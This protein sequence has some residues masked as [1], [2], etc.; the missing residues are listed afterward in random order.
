MKYLKLSFTSLLFILISLQ[1]FAQKINYVKNYYPYTHKA[2]LA[3]IDSNY[4]ESLQ[5]YQKAFHNV[6]GGFAK[7][8]YN[9]TVLAFLLKKEDIAF[10]YCDTLLAK[11]MGQ[12]SIDGILRNVTDWDDWEKW[13]GKLKARKKVKVKKFNLV[14]RKELEEIFKLDQDVRKKGGIE[15]Y[16]TDVKN[17]QRIKALI[18]QYGF[19]SEEVIGFEKVSDFFVPQYPYRIVLLHY[20]RLCKDDK[21]LYSFVKMLKKAIK[22]GELH[23]H[24]GSSLL[25]KELGE[26]HYFNLILFNI[27]NKDWYVPDFSEKDKK[28]LNKRRAK[29]GLESIEAYQKKAIFRNSK[30]RFFDFSSLRDNVTLPKSMTSQYYPKFKKINIKR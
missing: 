17:A 23:I 18:E 5:Y 13:Q 11:G 10:Q 19:P 12:S 24:L 25:D 2:E 15:V 14:Y 6:K 7:D 30:N 21:K 16:Q 9:A 28:A 26:N 27:D 22:D 1:V 4:K 20:M 8:Y 3:L 29:L